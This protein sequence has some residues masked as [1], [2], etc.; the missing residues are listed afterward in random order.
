MC[1]QATH[2]GRKPLSSPAPFNHPKP[3]LLNF[4][5]SERA[6]SYVSGMKRIKVSSYYGV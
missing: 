3:F 4:I 6:K 5:P 2:G 1:P